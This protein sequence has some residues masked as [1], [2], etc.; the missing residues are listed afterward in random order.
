MLT[1]LN[2][3]LIT[4]L[5]F[6]LN[7]FR[8]YDIQQTPWENGL[9]KLRMAFKNDYPTSPPKCTFEPVLFHPNVNSSGMVFTSMLNERKDWRPEYTIKI[10]LLMIQDLLMAPFIDDPANTEASSMY[11][12]NRPEYDRRAREQAQAQPLLTG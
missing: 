4:K 1:C 2:P 7:C 6:N 11:R 8:L 3:H 10:V 9:F 5:F 12:H